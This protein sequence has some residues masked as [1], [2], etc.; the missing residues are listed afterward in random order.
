MARGTLIGPSHTPENK[1]H[2]VRLRT[3]Q[4]LRLDAFFCAPRVQHR[5]RRPLL[6]VSRNCRPKSPGHRNSPQARVN[7]FTVLCSGNPNPDPPPPPSAPPAWWQITQE[8]GHNPFM[9]VNEKAVRK[10]TGAKSGVDAMKR[11]REMKNSFRPPPATP[12]RFPSL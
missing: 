3:I 9:R 2:K 5:G 8:L 10:S 12:G 4:Q 1:G 6:V 11:L 7:H